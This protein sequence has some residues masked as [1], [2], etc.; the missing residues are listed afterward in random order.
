MQLHLVLI[1][2]AV[3]VSS[4]NLLVALLI[5]LLQLNMIKIYMRLNNI[6]AFMCNMRDKNTHP[7]HNQ[8]AGSHD[9]LMKS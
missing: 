3:V 9:E 7:H 1:S 6:V 5:N 4:L 2:I 8:G